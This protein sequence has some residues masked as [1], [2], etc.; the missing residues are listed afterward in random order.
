MWRVNE[1]E[2]YAVLNGAREVE[3]WTAWAFINSEQSG[4]L[5]NFTMER[6]AG[7]GRADATVLNVSEY[8]PGAAAE[9]PRARDSCG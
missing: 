3:C 1:I 6:I 2:N 9:A 7:V 8:P 5:R 4:V